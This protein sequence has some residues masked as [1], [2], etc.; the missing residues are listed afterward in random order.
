MAGA[1]RSIR[2]ALSTFDFSGA[3]RITDDQRALNPLRGRL[4]W[5]DMRVLSGG[6]MALPLLLALL[7]AAP[8]L[9]LLT[10]APHAPAGSV[11]AWTVHVPG[12]IRW[13]QVTPAGA[14]LVSTDGALVAVDIERGQLLWQ[15]QEPGGLPVDSVDIVGGLVFIEAEK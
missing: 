4:S 11:A 12:D 6:F 5:G 15:K 3:L 9:S 10:P 7:Q 1:P 8:V 13:Q 2:N 14:L